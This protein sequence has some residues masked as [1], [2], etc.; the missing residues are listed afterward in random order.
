[1]HRE[2]RG[3]HL[4]AHRAHCAVR[5]LGLQQVF[6]QPARALQGGTAPLLDQIGPGA[7]HAVHAQLLEF[8]GK[9]THGRP[10]R[11]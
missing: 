5:G 10:P 1:M 4:M 7:C 3:M 8:D 6:E 9:L 11:W 2:L